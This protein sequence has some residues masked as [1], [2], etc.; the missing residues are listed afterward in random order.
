MNSAYTFQS[1]SI[2]YFFK[3]AGKTFQQGSSNVTLKPLAAPEDSLSVLPF[4]SPMIPGGGVGLILAVD[5]ADG[6]KTLLLILELARVG[7]IVRVAA[8]VVFERDREWVAVVEVVGMD[9]PEAKRVR[10]GAL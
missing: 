6:P 9:D 1:S 3:A 2:L 7:G 5:R 4:S 8:E 10:G